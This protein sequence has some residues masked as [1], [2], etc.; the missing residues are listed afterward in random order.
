MQE[1]TGLREFA[2]RV[3]AGAIGGLVATI[4]M[5]VFMLW[6]HQRMPWSRRDALPPRQITR[7]ALA[8]IGVH[9]KFTRSQEKA[10]TVANHFAYGATVGAGYGCVASAETLRGAVSEGAIYGAG[11]WAASYLGWLPEAGFYKPAVREPLERHAMMIAAHVVWGG[12]LGLATFYL[13]RRNTREGDSAL[14]DSSR[15]RPSLAGERLSGA[16]G[17]R[18]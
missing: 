7:N 18:N 5:S 12:T 15:L 11:V 14:R 3:R 17:S 2:K 8:A 1:R 4:P 9:G 13:R 6:W 16:T 10:I